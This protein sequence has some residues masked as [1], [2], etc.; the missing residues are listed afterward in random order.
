VR[1]GFEAFCRTEYAAVVRLGFWMTGNRQD[2]LDIAQE[3][4][5]RAYERGG[6]SPRW[7][8]QMPGFSGW[9]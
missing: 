2:A 4:F 9:R 7:T 8:G 5:A 6:G 1:G 3:A